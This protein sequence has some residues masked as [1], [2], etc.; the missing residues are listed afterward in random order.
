MYKVIY[1]NDIDMVTSQDFELLTDAQT[2]AATLDWYKI[3]T[4]T[5]SRTIADVT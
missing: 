1:F 5:A 3:V 2:F 4:F